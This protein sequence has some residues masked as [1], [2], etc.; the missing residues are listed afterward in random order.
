MLTSVMA[1]QSKELSVDGNVHSGSLH[2]DNFLSISF[3]SLQLQESTGE[4]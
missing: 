2:G 1:C 4:I 3:V